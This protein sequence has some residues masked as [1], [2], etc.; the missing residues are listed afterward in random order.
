MNIEIYGKDRMSSKFKVS[1][2]N[3]LKLLVQIK[4]KFY[5]KFIKIRRLFCSWLT[6][7]KRHIL[8]LRR[9]VIL[10]LINH[11]ISIKKWKQMY[12]HFI[13]AYNYDALDMFKI[14]FLYPKW[15]WFYKD[16]IRFFITPWVTFLVLSLIDD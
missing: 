6:L 1:P 4:K 7:R 12:P 3:Y 2:N 10:L 14:L 8:S 13:I 5:K 11:S 15:F 9:L 16:S